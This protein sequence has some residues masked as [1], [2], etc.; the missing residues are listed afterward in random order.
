MKLISLAFVS[1]ARALSAGLASGQRP[2]L[3]GYQP[4]ILSSDLQDDTFTLVKSSLFPNHQLRIR[5]LQNFCDP[6][7]KKY[8]G[9]LDIS[10]EKHLFFWFFESRNRPHEAPLGVWMNGVLRM[11]PELH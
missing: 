2:I 11:V 4:E 3:A 6:S 5:T 9:Y 10:S 7:V 1:A 8:S